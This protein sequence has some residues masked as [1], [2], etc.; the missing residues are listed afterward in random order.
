M[1]AVLN[2]TKVLHEDQRYE[3]VKK[4]LDYI[5]TKETFAPMEQKGKV[6]STHRIIFVIS[7][8][9]ICHFATRF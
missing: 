1:M 8:T 6:F 9:V 2:F 3:V 4:I 7:P 5:K